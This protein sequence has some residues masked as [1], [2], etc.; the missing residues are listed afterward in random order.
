MWLCPWPRTPTHATRTVSFGLDRAVLY[1]VT[2]AAE[3]IR[4]CLRFILPPYPLPRVP[5]CKRSSVQDTPECST[6]DVG[7]RLSRNTTHI[8]HSVIALK[9][10]I[11]F[12][13]VTFENVRPE[14][15]LLKSRHIRFRSMRAGNTSPPEN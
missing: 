15:Q 9:F 10:A 1:A 4:K 11:E 6:K 14:Y 2:A 3:P 7:L 13:K 5:G 12:S 8:K